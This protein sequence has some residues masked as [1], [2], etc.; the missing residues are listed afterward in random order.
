VQSKKAVY[1]SGGGSAGHRSS[2]RFFS[3]HRKDV[4]LRAQC[5]N[6][7]FQQ[8]KKNENVTSFD[9][10]SCKLDTGTTSLELT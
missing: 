7:F 2:I 5:N 9:E 10:L 8:L 3:T 4:S 1:A 6:Y